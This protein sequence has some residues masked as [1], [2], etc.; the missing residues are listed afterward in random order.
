MDNWTPEQLRIMKAGGNQQ[1]M[2]YLKSKGVVLFSSSS[3]EDV[4]GRYDN[5][6]AVGYK[7]QLKAKANGQ[8]NDIDVQPSSKSSIQRQRQRQRRGRKISSSNERKQ[9]QDL[10]Q[11][12]AAN[13]K[14]S[15]TPAQEAHQITTSLLRTKHLMEQ[16]LDRTQETSSA[17]ESDAQALKQAREG[18]S[19]IVHST[20]GAKG[21]LRALKRQDVQERV[22]LICAVGFYCIVALYVLW[23]RIRVPFLLW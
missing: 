18:Q 14:L 16:N 4:R 15:L 2:D 20:K 5:E 17:L 7:V 3:R 6:A 12:A 11:G 8:P 1:C 23:T 21:A 22:V 13:G 19:D 9:K 10:F